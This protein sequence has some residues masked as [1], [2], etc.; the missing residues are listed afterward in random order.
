MSRVLQRKSQKK[1]GN[2]GRSK[3]CEIK[4]QHYLLQATSFSIPLPPLHT[5]TAPNHTSGTKE[6]EPNRN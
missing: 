4:T 3:K 6:T 5:H 2:N 1:P